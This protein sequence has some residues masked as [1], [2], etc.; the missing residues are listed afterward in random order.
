MDTAH[1]IP[2]LKHSL[3]DDSAFRPESLIAAVRAERGIVDS[4]IP[5]ICVLDFD[6]D[7]T[8]WLARAGLSKPATAWACF[9]SSM[10]QVELEGVAIGIVDR[11][12]GGPYAVLIAEQMLAMGGKIIVGMTSAGRVASSL[13][14]PSF[15]IPTRALR[16]EGT[17]YHYLPPS[18]F[19]EAPSDLS[20][21]LARA[22]EAVGVPVQRGAVWTTDAPYRETTEQI[23][24]HASTG[25]L[26][27]E[28]QAASLFALGAARSVP[29]GV[30]AHVT[31]A[32]DHEGK[33]FDKGSERLWLEVLG[34]I[35]KVGSE[36]IRT[37]TQVLS[38]TTPE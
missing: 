33:D 11:T 1:E 34:G 21:R 27:V 15:V 19:V 30:V 35:A 14:I 36:I 23:R 32:T 3:Q 7:L 38:D 20:S 25:I 18:E 37:P 12:I 24:R 17:S 16:D 8:D 31:N 13:P 29:I 22:L 9:H 28:M 6:G 5:E 26:A 2:L 10:Q 4:A